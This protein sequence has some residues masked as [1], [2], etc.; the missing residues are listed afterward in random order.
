MNLTS[1]ELKVTGSQEL[2]LEVQ[3]D[4]ETA[5]QRSIS[6]ILDEEEKKQQEEERD[7]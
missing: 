4:L 5:Q 6:S 7:I 3:K 2:E 1:S